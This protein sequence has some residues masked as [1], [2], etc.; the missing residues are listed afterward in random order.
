MSFPS[1]R[2]FDFYELS[3]EKDETRIVNLIEAIDSATDWL[4]DAVRGTDQYERGNELR[5]A[6]NAFLSKEMP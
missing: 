6:L 5:L 2:G 1:K 3:P 4:C